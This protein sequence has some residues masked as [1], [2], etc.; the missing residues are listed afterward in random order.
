MTEEEMT[1]KLEHNDEAKRLLAKVVMRFGN[2]SWVR[3]LT[4][5]DK[6]TTWIRD[7]DTLRAV[8]KGK[9]LDADF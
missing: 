3:L 2:N 8:L 6:Y 9:N 5:D 7:M 1:Y 4:N